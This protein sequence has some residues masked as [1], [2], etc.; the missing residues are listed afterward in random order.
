M[1]VD[2]DVSMGV[3]G[4]VGPDA[5][6]RAA[7]L[8]AGITVTNPLRAW[9]GADAETVREGERQITRF[10]QH[11]ERLVTAEDFA[12]IARRAPGVDIGRIEVLPAYSPALGASEPGDAPGAVTLMVLPRFDPDHP[13]APEPDRLFLEALCRHLDPRRLVTTEIFLCPA[14]YKDV[15]IS[16]GID[17][18]AGYDFPVVRESVR[19]ALLRLLSPLPADPGTALAEQEALLATPQQAMRDRGWPLRKPVDRLELMAEVNRTPGVRL[20]KELFVAEGTLPST[21]SIAFTGLQLPRVRGIAIALGDARSLDDVR[22]TGVTT[23][24]T[25]PAFV[26]VPVLPEEC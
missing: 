13:D 23:T 14:E 9:G 26:P 5:I 24:T 20:V 15:W 3:R 22:G 1:R 18:V 19:G 17:M 2:Y 4:N 16:V 7:A 11:R 6:N 25:D 12:T 10:L 21:E 8:P